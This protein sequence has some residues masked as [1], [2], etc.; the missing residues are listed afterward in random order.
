MTLARKLPRRP[1]TRGPARRERS[2]RR[3]RRMRGR[4]VV[5]RRRG[6]IARSAKIY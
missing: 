6:A 2:L 5:G 4:L 1:A 3:D